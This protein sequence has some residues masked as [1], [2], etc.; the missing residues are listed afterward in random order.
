MPE[1]NVILIHFKSSPYLKLESDW[2]PPP[3]YSCHYG[4]HGHI[5]GL[6]HICY[7]M[8]GFALTQMN[9]TKDTYHTQRHTNTHLN[10]KTKINQKHY[11]KLKKTNHKFQEKH[12]KF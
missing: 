5:L 1:N 8:C 12:V 2:L 4:D 6:P 7:G 10:N 11:N 9:I 3:E